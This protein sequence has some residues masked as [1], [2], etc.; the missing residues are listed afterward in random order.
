MKLSV[1]TK[2]GGGFG[3]ALIILAIL[4]SLAYW[5]ITKLTEATEQRQHT[6]QVLLHLEQVL[7]VMKDAETGQRGYVIT[8]RRSLSR[9]V[10]QR[11]GRH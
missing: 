9:P 7:S 10:Q 5:N 11:P 6:Q 3:L 8:G 4:A 1:G 2:I